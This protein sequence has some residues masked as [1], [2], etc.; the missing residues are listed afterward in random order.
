MRSRTENG[1]FAESNRIRAIL[2]ALKELGPMTARQIG[3]VLGCGE[4]NIA[5]H[6]LT[7]RKEQ[8]GIRVQGFDMSSATR[9]PR[10][11][12]IGSGPDEPFPQREYPSRI[13]RIKYPGM[14]R[15]E[16]RDLKALQAFAAEILP[17]R[18]EMLFRTAGRQP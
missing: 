5:L 16:I 17:F 18:D 10:I 12:A 3:E 13:K 4:K 8:K 6:I 9:K 2:K 1:K 14:S 7:Y 11:Y 15:D